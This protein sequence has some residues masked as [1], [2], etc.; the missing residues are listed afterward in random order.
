MTNSI[1]K[2]DFHVDGGVSLF[3]IRSRLHPIT[4]DNL[5]TGLTG[6]GARD[7]CAS[8]NVLNVPFSTETSISAFD[9]GGMGREAQLG[10]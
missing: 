2:L 5:L 9:I 1:T 6:V 8:K 4:S 10:I 3:L 7:A